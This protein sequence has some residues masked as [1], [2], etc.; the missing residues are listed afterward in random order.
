MAASRSSLP[1][2][3]ADADL[4]RL[5]WVNNAAFGEDKAAR[6]Q[7]ALKT[8]VDKWADH[9]TSAL[10]LHQWARAIQ[11]EGNLIVARSLARRGANAHRNSIGGRMCR[12]LISEIEAKSA[13]ITTERVWNAPL[14]NISVR[15]R[16][17]TNVYF[18]A[19]AYDWNAFLDKRRNRPEYLSD[20]ERRELLAKAPALAWST[21]LPPTPDF[22]EIGRA[23]V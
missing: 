4:A 13:S 8:F 12:N 11:S 19:V 14:P 18:R 2:A 23:H 6:Y 9:E 5:V 15:Y 17:L 1:C 10:A 3:T 20:A 22:K 7:A 21:N 16:N